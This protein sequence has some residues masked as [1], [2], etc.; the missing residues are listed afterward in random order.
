MAGAY[1]LQVGS[2]AGVLVPANGITLPRL[3]CSRNADVSIVS[4]FPVLRRSLVTGPGTSTLTGTK[5][6]GT[7]LP[8][9]LPPHGVPASVL[10]PPGAPGASFVPASPC[11]CRRPLS[12]LPSAPRGLSYLRKHSLCTWFCSRNPGG[13]PQ[14]LACY[15]SASLTQSSSGRLWKSG[16]QGVSAGARGVG[17]ADLPWGPGVAL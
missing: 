13:F 17:W 11:A 9:L 10:V 1:A 3:P 12:R 7:C 5:S 4:A 6:A 2:E 15:R 16:I 8:C 14:V